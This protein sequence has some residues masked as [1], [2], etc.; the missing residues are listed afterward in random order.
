[1]THDQVSRE[2]DASAPGVGDIH[3]TARG[4]GARFNSGKT[5]F[6]YIPLALLAGAARVF[7]KVTTRPVNPYP[8]WNWAKG[9]AWSVPYECAL[10][11]LDAWYRGEASDPDTGES[12]LDHVICNLLMLKHY[13]TAWREGDDRPHGFLPE[14][15][16]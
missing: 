10:R 2:A 9:M 5:P 12:H 4:S 8:K 13:E 14:E 15:T 16:K 3:S 7:H 1:M 6:G 11:H